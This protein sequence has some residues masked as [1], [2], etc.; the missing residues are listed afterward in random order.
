MA[1]LRPGELNFREFDNS[2][3]PLSLGKV[4]TYVSGTNTL[5]STWADIDGDANN[6]NP[7]ILDA[8]GEANIFL[9]PGKNYRFVVKTADDV[10]I[11]TKDNIA[12]ASPAAAS[13]WLNVKSFG[14]VGD[15]V[16]DD[17]AAIQLA[18]D[19][20]TTS[21]R[22]TLYIPAGTYIVSDSI[23]ING[24]IN[25]VGDGMNNSV[26]SYTANNNPCLNWTAD[27][28]YSHLADF[29]LIGA[30]A[31]RTRVVGY[32]S[33]G[34]RTCNTYT[35]PGSGQIASV[36]YIFERVWVEGFDFAGIEISDSFNCKFSDMRIRRNGVQGT[37]AAG[38]TDGQ[39]AGIYLTRINFT[40][41]S[42][43]GNDY[44]NCYITGNH[45][46]VDVAPGAGNDKAFNTRFDLCIFEENYVGID[47]RNTI[48]TGK[49]RYQFLNT[50]YFEANLFAGALL[51]EATTIACYQNS[52]TAGTGIAPSWS[53]DGADGITFE[54]RYVEDRPARFRVGNNSA[55][56]YDDTDNVAFS[57]EKGETT[58]YINVLK[59][60]NDTGVTLTRGAGSADTD[61]VK[62]VTGSG[63]PE[64]AITANSASLYLRRDGTAL[65]NILYL[66]TTDASNTGWIT[67]GALQGSTANRPTADATNKGVRYYDTDI[68]RSVVSNGA[69]VWREYNGLSTVKDTY[70]NIPSGLVGAKFY[71]TDLAA[72]FMYDGGRWRLVYKNPT[73]AGVTNGGTTTVTAR[74]GHVIG[75]TTGAAVAT[76]TLTLP[77][78]TD[79]VSGDVVK[80][81]TSNG[82]VALTVNMSVGTIV[83]APTTMTA[84][85]TIEFI[86]NDGSSTWYR[87]M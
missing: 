46:G 26:L 29:K 36:L 34:I 51:D 87:V 48:G 55:A 14:A 43:T 19:A 63:T 20:A 59:V 73:F 39:G 8:R 42:T 12:G 49:G 38:G 37:L 17:T 25:M 47:L 28:S 56:P 13:E 45:I 27:G 3:N 33:T 68:L 23:D 82:V 76:H 79:A 77:S 58:N 10:T 9:P 18:V 22:G 83:N 75:T 69:G 53:T 11:K 50:C 70:A 41:S 54:G 61:D 84:G 4:Y 57:V 72:E 71:A 64:A 31:S 7:V 60:R 86:Y 67:V 35:G 5:L 15:G 52:T 21:P 62:I 44:T 24:R 81:T 78:G 74:G 65:S 2:G 32:T 80:F 1:G 16:T 6:T 66:K 30:G 85:Q 40:G